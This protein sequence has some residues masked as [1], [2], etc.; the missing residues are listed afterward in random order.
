MVTTTL[1]DLEAA[2]GKGLTGGGSWL[3]GSDV[4]RVA[5]HAHHYLAIFDDAKPLALYHTK[6]FASPAQRITLYATDR[7]CSKPGC[8]APA[9][10][11]QAHHVSGG[12]TTP[13]RARSGGS[14][15]RDAAMRQLE[16]SV[17]AGLRARS[18]EVVERLVDTGPDHERSWAARWVT[19]TASEA[20][21]SCFAKLVALGEARAGL[22]WT[23][24]EREAYDRVSRLKQEQRR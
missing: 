10:H 22:E 24:A 21:K 7:G 3:P 20:Y 11:S 13:W 8:D 15:Q 18:A 6:R 17:K 19:D 16:R 5:S 1:K 2:T 23:A 14:P 12:S 4:I 9:Y